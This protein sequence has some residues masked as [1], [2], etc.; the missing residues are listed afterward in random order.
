M[1]L[2]LTGKRAL[3]TGGSRGIGKAIAFQLASE[4][5]DV[6]IAARNLAPLEATA[7]EIAAATGRKIV[8]IVADMGDDAAVE[9]MVA[10]AMQALGGIDILVN[11]AAAPGGTVPSAKI[12][13]VTAENLLFD[14]N[15]KVAGYM[16]AAKAIAPHMAKGGWGRIINIGGGAAR[17]SGNYIASIRNSA[18]SSL[19]KNLADELGPK[20]INVVAIHPGTTKAGQPMTEEFEKRTTQSVSI[21]RLIEAKEIAYV[22]AFLASPKSI[23]I[24]GETVAT[25]G[26]IIGP[27]TY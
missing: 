5:V 22:V 21:G 20:G 3:V 14:V 9:A 24:N 11:D 27:I 17:R 13:Q 6:A 18:V 26:G 19:T 8:P 15:V 12:E 2:E 4:G 23:A 16:R 10:K 7:R 25:G 1:D